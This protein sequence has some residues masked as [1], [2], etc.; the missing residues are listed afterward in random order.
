VLWA[1]LLALAGCGASGGAADTAALADDGPDVAMPDAALPE[2]P[3]I[4]RD[5]GQAGD[6]GTDDAAIPED[7]PPA[8]PGVEADH[9]RPDP[10]PDPASDVGPADPG[11]PPPSGCIL[12]DFRPYY[13]NMHAHSSHSDGDGSPAEAFAWARDQAGLDIQFITDHLEQLY[14]IPCL[15]QAPD[16]DECIRHA[17]DASVPGKFL[18]GCGFEYGSSIGGLTGHNNVYFSAGLFPCIQLY[19]KDFYQS[20]K[21]DPDCIAQFNHPGDVLTHTWNNFEYDAGVDAKMNLF[22]FNSESDP[23]LLYFIALDAGWHLSPLYDQDNHG[24]DWGTKNEARAGFYLDDL[25]MPSLHAAMRERRSFAT[26][27]RNASIV[28]RTAE[29]C[30]MGSILSGVGAVTLAVEAT[31]PDPADG[32]TSLELWGPG[33]DLVQQTD[34]AGAGQC[35]ISATFQVLEPTYV[36]ARALQ[37]DGHYL[38]SAPIWMSR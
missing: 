23:F 22:E 30:W 25:S 34:C 17:Q 21:N 29:G 16:W 24:A 26:T 1:G 38:V 7:A 31:D 8:D 28:L 5:P 10:G 14:Y 33:H 35:T 4:G 37:A 3:G 9:G 12:G 15:G 20:V 36:L 27:D 13:G 32:F 6:E 2:D 18:A 11:P 19:F